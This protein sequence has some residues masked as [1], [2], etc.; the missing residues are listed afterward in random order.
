MASYK[1]AIQ[2]LVDNDDTE[3]VVEEGYLSVTACLVADLFD[4][5]SIK[6]RIDLINGLFFANRID[7]EDRDNLVANAKKLGG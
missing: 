3:W 6:V 1:Q 4:K 5:D 2:W 7:K